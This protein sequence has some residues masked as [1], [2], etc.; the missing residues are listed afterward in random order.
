MHLFS[1]KLTAIVQS[2]SKKGGIT[3]VASCKGVKSATMKLSAE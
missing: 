1:G 2:T 3:F